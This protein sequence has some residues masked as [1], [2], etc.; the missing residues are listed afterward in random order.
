MINLIRILDE[1]EDCY[2]EFD[3]DN[4]R[5]LLERD[6]KSIECEV[7]FTFDSEDTNKKSMFLESFI[8]VSIYDLSK[9]STESFS[10]FFSAIPPCHV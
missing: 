6:G 7:L 9:D 4:G 3:I 1:L 2:M 10:I 5:I 8:A